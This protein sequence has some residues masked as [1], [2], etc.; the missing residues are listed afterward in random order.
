MIGE[1]RRVSA[2]PVAATLILAAL[3]VVLPA[4]ALHLQGF[5]GLGQ[6][7]GIQWNDSWAGVF[8]CPL[9]V[10]R[11]GIVKVA[12]NGGNLVATKVNGDE[13]EREGAVVWYGAV[14]RSGIN[15]GDLPLSFPVDVSNPR[16][17]RRLPGRL[18]L[19]TPDRMIIEAGGAVVELTRGTQPPQAVATTAPVAGAPPEAGATSPLAAPPSGNAAPM[20][21]APNAS[22]QPRCELGKVG[23][24]SDAERAIV[25]KLVGGELAEITKV[26]LNGDGRPDFFV[27]GGD[28]GNMQVCGTDVYLSQGQTYVRVFGTEV[29]AAGESS[30]ITVGSSVTRGLCDL[31]VDSVRLSWNGQAYK[32][33][34]KVR[35]AKNAPAPSPPPK[36]AADSPAALMVDKPFMAI[37]R[38]A[39]GRKDKEP[40]LVDGPE[41][42]HKNVEIEGTTYVVATSCKPHDCGDNTILVLYSAAKKVVYG[43]IVRPGDARLLGAPPPAVS[44][45]LER[46]WTLEFRSR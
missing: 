33:N 2:A 6:P 14:P 46:E 12:R 26:D 18:T 35:P 4:C 38:K 24:A 31:N 29:A 17:G 19:V 10:A 11:A 22:G 30:E 32:A 45:A 42:Q 40:W 5:G 44:A 13:C 15:P 7:S 1:G 39:L 36:I 34:G 43:K 27:T 8:Q 20:A 25:A 41:T 37:Y 16:G 21:A 9:G 23:A 3:T 28:C